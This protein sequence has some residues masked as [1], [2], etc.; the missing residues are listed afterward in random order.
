MYLWLC[1]VN[2]FSVSREE[3]LA[4]A[5]CLVVAILSKLHRGVPVDNIHEDSHVAEDTCISDTWSPFLATKCKHLHQRPKIFFYLDNLNVKDSKVNYPIVFYILQINLHVICFV[6]KTR[7]YNI[8]NKCGQCIT[9]FFF[10]NS[11][12]REV[13]Q[14]H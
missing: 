1:I 2:F 12:H 9:F 14:T 7:R 11:E 5:D 13:S 8:T 3:M 6:Y 10:T 4:D